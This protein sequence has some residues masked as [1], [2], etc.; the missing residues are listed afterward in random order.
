[1][2]ISKRSMS[3]AEIRRR[4]AV[5]GHISRTTSTLGLTGL[6]LLGA[7]TK[8]GRAVLRKIP[9]VAEKVAEHPVG[10][11]KI[12]EGAQNL[13]VV[14]SGIGAVGGFNFASYTK[15][16]S[17]KKRATVVKAYD[18]EGNRMK[19][20]KA[21]ETGTTLAAGAG[22]ASTVH[23]GVKHLQ[24]R[25]G[26]K[27]YDGAAYKGVKIK[28]GDRAGSL[29]IVRT[30]A[31]HKVVDAEALRLRSKTGKGALIAAGATAGAIA[32]NRKIHHAR[33]EGGSWQPYV[34][35]SATSA[36]GVVHD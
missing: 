35:K 27:E 15:A 6:G 3:D 11:N 22:A 19:R 9:K 23:Q 33:S 34:S 4:K 30:S 26:V 10:A 12:R 8:P 25:K 21:Y 1:M 29:N 31:P 18:P 14:S 13:G 28:S 24:A 16:E 2:T 20:A 17:Q 36:F 32:L 5:Q 7:S